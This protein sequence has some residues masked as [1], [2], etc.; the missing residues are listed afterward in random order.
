MFRLV[1]DPCRIHEHWAL[2]QQVSLNMVLE[3]SKCMIRPT[4]ETSN[5]TIVDS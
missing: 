5:K 4:D 3:G 1:K 2:L